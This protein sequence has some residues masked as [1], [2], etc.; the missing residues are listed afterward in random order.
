MGH[1]AMKFGD[2]FASSWLPY[3]SLRFEPLLLSRLQTYLRFAALL[4]LSYVDPCQL[5]HMNFGACWDIVVLYCY[6]F[7]C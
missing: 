6:S 1:I 4:E 7:L 3:C 2:R 5:R